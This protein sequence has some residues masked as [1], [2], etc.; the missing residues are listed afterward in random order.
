MPALIIFLL[1]VSV[2]AII[3]YGVL[4][5]INAAPKIRTLVWCVYAVIVLLYL[6]SLNI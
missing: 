5:F 1:Y 4:Y 3:I 2:G 6:I